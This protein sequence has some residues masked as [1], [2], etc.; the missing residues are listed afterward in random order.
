MEGGG[1]VTVKPAAECD[2]TITLH[3]LVLVFYGGT[4]VLAEDV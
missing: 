4:C 3:C 2:G 1:A